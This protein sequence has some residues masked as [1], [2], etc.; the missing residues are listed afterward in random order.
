MLT[1]GFSRMDYDT[2]RDRCVQNDPADAI[3]YRVVET[4]GWLSGCK[5]LIPPSSVRRV[6]WDNDMIEVR[7]TRQQGLRSKYTYA[8]AS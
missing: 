1:A 2:D 8:R 5:V 4:G 7:L 3:R 6:A